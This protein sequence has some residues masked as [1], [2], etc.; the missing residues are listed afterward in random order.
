M[1]LLTRILNWLTRKQAPVLGVN[2]HMR[3]LLKR[4]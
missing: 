4:K 1:K 2:A 3:A